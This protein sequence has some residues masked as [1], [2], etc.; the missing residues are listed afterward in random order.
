MQAEAASAP[1]SGA[2]QQGVHGLPP[3]PPRDRGSSWRSGEPYRQGQAQGERGVYHPSQER[4][5]TL[6]EIQSDMLMADQ[7]E[8]LHTIAEQR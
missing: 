2:L 7:L 3:P 6:M 4:G 8:M 5:P 1:R